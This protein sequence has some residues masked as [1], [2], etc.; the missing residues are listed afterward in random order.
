M[1]L[2]LLL[3]IGLL[4]AIAVAIVSYGLLQLFLVYHPSKIGES[5]EQKALSEAMRSDDFATAASLNQSIQNDPN[6]TAEEKA[7]ALYATLGAQYR[8]AGDTGTRLQ[9]VWDMK[10]AIMDPAVSLRTRVNILNVLSN[11][12]SVSGNDAAVFAEV[13]KGTPF[14]QYLVPGDQ[15]S[16]ALNLAEWSYSMMPTNFAAMRIAR[17]YTEKIFFNPDQTAK[18]TKENASIAADYVEK[19]DA[20]SLQDEKEN[21]TY[22]DGSAYLVFRFWRTVV[23]GRLANQIGEPY[24]S[25]YHQT[26]DDFISFAK[27]RKDVFSEEYLSYARLYFAAQL[28]RDSDTAGAKAQLDLLASEIEAIPDKDVSVFLQFLRNEYRDRPTGATWKNLVENQY[29]VSSSFKAAV[30]KIIVGAQE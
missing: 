26:Y 3:P 5:P 2:R 29:K 6:K 18:T 16:S 15:Y 17:L 25:Q 9:E 22:L 28:V 23:I 30:E 19:A 20:L 7:L 8:L 12:Y 1:S 21:P 10:I 27:A 24:V 13:Y 11:Q 4:L 14:N